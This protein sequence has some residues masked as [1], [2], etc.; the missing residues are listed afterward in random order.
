MDVP[1]LAELAGSF[2]VTPPLLAAAGYCPLRLSVCVLKN[3]VSINL[4]LFINESQV[5]QFT[6]TN[7]K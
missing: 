6:Q 3:M 5:N 2:Q 7:T 1:E 4:K